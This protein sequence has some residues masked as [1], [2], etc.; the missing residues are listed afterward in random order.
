MHTMPSKTFTSSEVT[1]ARLDTELLGN[2]LACR[3]WGPQLSAVDLAACHAI[4][5]QLTMP[6]GGGSPGR[7]H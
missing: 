1:V 4:A 5:G 6:E 7:W 2:E 3:G